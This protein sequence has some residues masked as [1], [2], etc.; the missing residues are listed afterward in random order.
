MRN[1]F[2]IPRHIDAFLPEVGIAT[3]ELIGLNERRFF[4]SVRPSQSMG[5]SKAGESSRL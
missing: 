1:G 4:C 3:P 2:F 5:E